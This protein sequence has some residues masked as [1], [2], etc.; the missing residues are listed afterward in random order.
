MDIRGFFAAASTR[1]TSKEAEAEAEEAAAAE[2]ERDPNN[3]HLEQV[4]QLEENNN[5]NKTIQPK[6]VSYSAQWTAVVAAVTAD[7]PHLLSDS[8]N[9]SISAFSALSPPAADAFVRLMLRKHKV[10]RVRRLAWDDRLATEDANSDK[11]DKVDKVDKLDK[12]D[13]QALFAELAA[14]SLL[15]LDPP[16][17]S[18]Q[19]LQLLV[20][21][22]L[23]DLAKQYKIPKHSSLSVSALQAALMDNLASITQF[24]FSFSS[25]QRSPS[26]ILLGKLKNILGPCIYIPDHVV[27]TFYRLFIIYNRERE[28]PENPFL[29][30]IRTNLKANRLVY[31]KYQIHRISITWPTR[32]DLLDYISVLKLQHEVESLLATIT[33]ATSPQ[34]RENIE[35]S[36]IT[37][38]ETCIPI[39]KTWV[40][41]QPDGHV[42]GI[43]WLAT[44][45]AGMK[46]TSI[47][48]HLILLYTRH[49]K[50]V[51]ACNIITLLLDRKLIGVRRGRGDLWDTYMKALVRLGKHAESFEVGCEALRDSAVEFGRRREIENR[52]VK[53]GNKLGRK[54]K[55]V[56][57][58]S[59]A[60]TLDK[61]HT[62][63]VEAKKTFSA[64]GRKA[65]Y[66]DV[67][68]G[69]DVEVEQL[70]LREFER[71]GF[72]G[73]HAENSVITTLFGIL[74]WDIL[75]DDTVPGV[76]TTPFQDAPMDLS[77]E[78]FYTA[79]KAAIDQRLSELVA[80][81]DTLHMEIISRVD[82]QHRPTATQCRGVYWNLFSRED[83]VQ[84]ASCF[85]GVQL[86]RIC[87]G[88]I[89]SYGAH[90]GGVPDLC[91]WRD[92]ELKLVEVKGEGDHLSHSQIMWLD[93]FTSCGV[94]VE[95]FKV[96]LPSIGVSKRKRK[97]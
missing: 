96:Q 20:R 6:G 91:V 81:P 49:G 31:N 11:V 34:D 86:A 67:A 73:V 8:D 65:L 64:T 26:D 30:H 9:N 24:S 78:F 35:N 63:V 69:E 5:S 42:S 44:F 52:L 27:E 47:L 68:T 50:D 54:D 82:D 32:Q 66:L 29:P 59:C 60:A 23:L 45:T 76:F 36:A 57:V 43:P 18:T 55:I 77:T 93:L 22:E 10:E 41:E 38:S 62:R 15:V 56:A 46:S 17:D 21:D 2:H 13:T 75:F 28:W 12:L 53:L 48:K 19:I 4:E 51:E 87:D 1:T 39:F 25:A 16:L 14:A 74:F 61:I 58:D 88:F 94:C 83:L 40:A 92:R 33:S 89:Q 3:K 84:V 79:R 95:L 70:A 72:K 85:N 97:K 90:S 7:E 71:I 37:L 80:N